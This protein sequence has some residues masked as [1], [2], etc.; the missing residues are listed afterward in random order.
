MSGPDIRRATLE[1]VLDMCARGELKLDK[2]APEG[3]DLDEDFWD[4]GVWVGP[5]PRQAQA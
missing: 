5:V 4:S 3:P 1:E 2:D